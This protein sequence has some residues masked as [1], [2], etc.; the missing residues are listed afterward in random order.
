MTVFAG[1]LATLFAD[2]NLGLDALYR[3][4]GNA[5]PLPVR[6]IARRPD[7]VFEFGET[8]IHADTALFDMQVAEVPDP[9]PG[10]TLEL[11]GETFVIQGE[12]LRDAGRLVWTLDVRPQ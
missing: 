4:G 3:A 7:R 12:P 1:A 10:D 6:L 5:A 11:D 8:R 2:R 9:R